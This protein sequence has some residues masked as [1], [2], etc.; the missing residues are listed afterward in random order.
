MAAIPLTVIGGF[1]GSGKT[2]LV[3]RVL[4]TLTGMRAAVLVNDFGTVDIDARLIAASGAKTIALTNGCICCSIGDDLTRALIRVV[5][6]RPAPDWI[7]IEASGVSD[8][9]KIAQVGLVDPG[10]AL[11]G[12][13]VLADAHSVRAHAEDALLAETVRRQLVAADLLVLN[14]ADLVSSQTLCATRQWIGGVAPDAWIYE[15]CDA[16]VP[17]GLL[18]SL[19]AAPGV[20]ESRP[21]R[22]NRA[23]ADRR[24]FDPLDHAHVFSAWSFETARVF[25]RR[26]L[27]ALLSDMPRGIV[28]AKGIVR[29]D[30]APGDATVLQFAGRSRMLRRYGPWSEGPS[31]IV[32]IG[33]S[34]VVDFDA[35]GQRLERALV[36]GDA[37][38]V[39]ANSANWR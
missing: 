21:P 20:A 31:R 28:R 18:C 26:A 17:L 39:Q 32:A 19:A 9:W 1:L 25:S 22:T 24:A 16:D 27:R 35:L 3:N 6:A 7:V 13:V 5:D 36:P 29:I 8:P 15:T 33:A 14:K 11:D 37:P 2:T 38:L 4:G 34:R 30:E 23:A 10:L 12:V